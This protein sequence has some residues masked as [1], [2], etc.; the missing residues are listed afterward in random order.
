MIDESDVLLA[1][2]G[3]QAG[4]EIKAGAIMNQKMVTVNVGQE[5][6]EL[7]PLFQRGRV[8]AVLDKGQFLGLIT[9]IDFLNYLRKRS[10]YA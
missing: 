3:N 9:P 4:F 7:I 8:V 2:V 10:G 5:L 1:V 6:S